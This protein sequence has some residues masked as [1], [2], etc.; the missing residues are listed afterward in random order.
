MFCPKCARDPFAHSFSYFGTAENG[1]SLYYTAPARVTSKDDYE[2]IATLKLHIQEIQ[3]DWIW[4]IDCSNM[5]LHNFFNLRFAVE[6]STILQIERLKGLKKV[7]IL[8][9]NI[10][11]YRVLQHIVSDL[12]RMIYVATNDTE[13]AKVCRD[14]EFSYDAKTWLKIA[15]VR[16]P[17]QHLDKVAE[18]TEAKLIAGS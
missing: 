5:E 13:I 12:Q 10:W 18:K 16:G 17:N 3:G 11:M 15:F 6:F 8:H 4:T 14:L 2:G 7:V 9:P 1:E